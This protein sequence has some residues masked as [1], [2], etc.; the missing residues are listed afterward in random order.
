MLLLTI[1]FISKGCLTPQMLESF[2]NGDYHVLAR[3]TLSGPEQTI[4]TPNF[5]IHYTT[6]GDDAVTQAYAESIAVYAEYSWQK[7]VVEFGW[8]APPPDYNQGG[9]NRYDI[10]IKNLGQGVLG[11]TA[12]EYTYSG[13]GTEGATSYIVI[14]KGIESYGYDLLRVTV[15][16]EFHHAIQFA[17][18]YN[19][20]PWFYENTST[21]MED[22][23]YDEVNDYIGYLNTNPSP[24]TTPHYPINTFSNLYQ[25]AGAIF[26]YFIYEYLGNNQQPMKD[27]WYQMGTNFGNN[28]L[29]DIFEVLS[30]NYSK[31]ESVILSYYA[32]WRFFT[33][34][35]WGDGAGYRYSEGSLYPS[36]SLFRNI[37]SYPRIDSNQTIP[38]KN[39]GGAQYIRLGPYNGDLRLI[40]KFKQCSGC[41]KVYL[42]RVPGP[43]I[44]DI[45]GDGDSIDVSF[46]FSGYNYGA[47]IV[48]SKVLGGQDIIY[49]FSIGPTTDIVEKIIDNDIKIVVNKRTINVIGKNKDYE[50]KLY[51][52]DGKIV[53]NSNLKPG[54]YVYHLRVKNK[55]FKGKVLVN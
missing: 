15:A 38:I 23:V 46:S 33:S 12:P 44:N 39:P 54:I 10:Y 31:P 17:Y 2:Q 29:F 48:V 42:I 6:S 3:P 14:G 47:I 43:V 34:T 40:M 16:H 18:T 37:T 50:L 53:Q 19:D 30:N 21:W 13:Y 36:V 5:I 32:I 52:S 1:H 11:Y 8:F 25:Y 51:S 41:A 20:A 28:T 24:I 9:D 27:I 35:R 7:Q 4:Q 49:K 45:T 26:P 22:M 55:I